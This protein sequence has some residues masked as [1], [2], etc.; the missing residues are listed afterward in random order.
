[1][2]ANVRPLTQIISTVSVLAFVLWFTCYVIR[3][4]AVNHVPQ[5]VYH[6]ETSYDNRVIMY[7]VVDR[8]NSSRSLSSPALS[9]YIEHLV[10]LNGFGQS[11]VETDRHSNA[12]TNHYTVGYWLSGSNEKFPD[13][14][15]T[16][17][18]IFD[19]IEI[20]KGYADEER[21]IVL[22][23]YDYRIIEDLD[24]QAGIEMD[25]F[26]YE[27]N[28]IAASVIGTPDEIRAFNYEEAKQFHAVTHRPENTTF[29]I[30]G[31]IS[32][33]Q[34]QRAMRDLDLLEKI[35]S[36]QETSPPQFALSQ[37]GQTALIY[38]DENAASRMILRRVV[39]LDQ[40][41]QFDLLEAQ[42]ALL[43]DILNSNLPGSLAKP[44]YYDGD[45]ARNI[46]V[47]IW[48]LDEDN[49]EIRIQAEPDYGIETS[50]L[51]RVVLDTLYSVATS[52]IPT[53]T[54]LRVLNRFETYWPDWKDE[55]NTEEWMVDYTIDRASH[56][57]EPLT[58][59]EL[60]KI[61]RQLS[62][63]LTTDLLRAFLGK[64][65]TVATFIGPQEVA[66]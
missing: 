17:S 40:P 20:S 29:V 44:L 62:Q 18:R 57:R 60:M 63:E 2:I 53:S 16:L 22:R 45:I 64:N 58:K 1:M 46:D 12:W 11:S 43:A 30:V 23:E 61:Y 25:A 54:Y 42:T 35:G 50:K 26:L 33:R 4:A 31:D 10:W 3:S 8:A 7:A 66:K 5:R 55:K 21:E 56:L 48:P 24:A 52:G 37:S 6:L 47:R 28:S 39:S 9:H 14:L 49:I 27:G 41:V 15:A 59:R 13:L 34:I 32:K 36:K 65:R 51:H 19:P 38:E